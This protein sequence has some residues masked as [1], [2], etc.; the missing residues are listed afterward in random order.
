MSFAAKEEMSWDF[1]VFEVVP[2][3]GN[4]AKPFLPSCWL[5]GIGRWWNLAKKN[6][7]RRSPLTE[8]IVNLVG[9]QEQVRKIQLEVGRMSS[10][11]QIQYLMKSRQGLLLSIESMKN[12]LQKKLPN[13]DQ[14]D[15]GLF[16]CVYRV[17]ERYG[18]S[19][20]DSIFW[21]FE[22]EYGHHPLDVLNYPEKFFRCVG[23]I[24]GIQSAKSLESTVVFEISNEFGTIV[25]KHANTLSI[26][27]STKSKLKSLSEGTFA[28]ALP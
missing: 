16:Q 18:Q 15:L 1:P 23:K 3:Q 24:L 25:Q 14:V 19:V 2:F 13:S 28:T 9:A 22:Y 7:A 4:S 20:I 12:E 11:T 6:K 26:I 10:K 27:K 21:S 17:L 8:L 5:I